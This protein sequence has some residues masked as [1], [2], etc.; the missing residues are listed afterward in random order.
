M[1]VA[2]EFLKAYPEIDIRLMLADRV[3]NLHEEG[4]DLAARIGELP[5]SSL[6]ATRVG[7]IR[8]VVCGSPGYFKTHGTPRN[9]GE[10]SRHQCVAFD[11]LMS[12]Q[13]WKFI[14]NGKPAVIPIR[15]RLIVNNAEAAIE[16]ASAAVGITRV[17]SYQ[18]AS[19]FR[20]GKL[21]RVLQ[22]F[23][24]PASPANFVYAGQGRLPIKLRA[25][26]D[27]AAPRLREKLAH[28]E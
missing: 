2:A 10:L 12:Q 3:F 1:P 11:G 15:P 14:V 4:V 21:V 19:A 6:V 25:F 22:K 16:A 24:P 28:L 13:D 20:S 8:Q 23:E 9:L 27:F 7:T 26:I 17:L 18:A 5:D